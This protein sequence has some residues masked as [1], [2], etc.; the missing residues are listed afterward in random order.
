VSRVE[1]WLRG[2]VA[3]VPVR[4][5]PAAHA[6]LNAL[7][8]FE[9]A[10]GARS[11]AE[12]W[13]APEGGASVGY[14]VRHTIGALDRLQTYARGAVLDERQRAALKAE[15]IAPDPWPDAAT[16]M[17]DV[18]AAI[19]H[20]IDVLRATDPDSLDA[21]APSAGD[22]CRRRLPGSCFTPPST[23]RDTR[24]RPSR[25]QSSSPETP[26]LRD[27]DRAEATGGVVRARR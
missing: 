7:D 5:Q 8:D 22:N 19:E 2:P 26:N 24:V 12:V 1:A 21:R 16:L 13:A 18:R 6:L 15:S 23:P 4:L 11:A 9:I 20:A 3:G 27:S 10:L 17:D 25:R 14:H